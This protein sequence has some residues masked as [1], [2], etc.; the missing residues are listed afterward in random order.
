LPKGKCVDHDDICNSNNSI[1]GSILELVPRVGR[2]DL[3]VLGKLGLDR[4]D[5]AGELRAGKVAAV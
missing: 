3:D 4:A 5:L 1:A 2:A